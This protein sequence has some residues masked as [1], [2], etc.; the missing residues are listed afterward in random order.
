MFQ[1]QGDE[2]LP[3]LSGNQFIYDYCGAIIEKLCFQNVFRPDENEK[4][5]FSN[6]CSLKSIF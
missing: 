1:K 5:A 2:V 4:P 3:A 6:S